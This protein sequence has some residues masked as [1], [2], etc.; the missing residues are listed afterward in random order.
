VLGSVCGYVVRADDGAPVV[1]AA[2]DV[3][4]GPGTGRPRRVVTNTA[5][6]FALSGLPEGQ[7]VLSATSSAGRGQATVHVFESAASDVTIEVAGYPRV[8]ERPTTGPERRMRGRV[9][10]RV[11]RADSGEPIADAAI[12]VVRGAGPAPDIAP[13]TDSAG[14]FALDEL[15]AGDWL[16]RAHAPGGE[17]GEATARVAGGFVT[18][19]V[20]EVAGAGG[21][22]TPERD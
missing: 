11:V 10:G 6:T 16:L 3:V 9:R 17:T 5:G 13:M 15:P 1:N 12:T 20:I 4:R 21:W 22:G 8:V 14:G 18:D 19:I 2:V 7:W